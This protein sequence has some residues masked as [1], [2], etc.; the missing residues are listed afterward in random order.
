MQ[1]YKFIDFFRAIA[2]FWVL[3]AHCMIWGGWYGIPL[4]SAKIAVDL[5]MVIS[6]F[7]MAST[8]IDKNGSCMLLDFRSWIYFWIKRF[9]RLAPAYYLSLFLAIISSDYFLA[10]YKLLQ[11]LNP[12]IWIDGGV[13]DPMRIEYSLTNI[14]LHISFLF[15]LYP[16]WSFSTFLPDWSLSLEMQFYFVFPILILIML[17]KGVLKIGFLICILFIPIGILISHYFQFYE[18]SL[19]FFK[20]QYFIAGIILYSIISGKELLVRKV[21]KLLSAILLILCEFNYNYGMEIITLPILLIFMFVFGY[22]E[23]NN[24][25]RVIISFIN[26][27]II[28]FASDVSYGV[29]LFHGFFISLS[30]YLI[31]SNEFLLSLNPSL[32]VLFLFTFV[33]I[34]SYS[35]AYFVHRLVENPGIAFGKKIVNKLNLKKG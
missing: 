31:T 34:M 32:R 30:G 23:M 4:P 25:S 18:P 16:S 6:G 3:L 14:L 2:A 27:K 10:G 21:F 13:Y 1:N 35:F 22:I 7:L 33:V 28:K 26:F 12:T 19:L 5:F 11:N 20:L 24:Y 8:N 9:F 29:Y 17:K 15:G